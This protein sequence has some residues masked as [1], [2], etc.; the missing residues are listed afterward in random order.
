MDIKHNFK[1]LL[2]WDVHGWGTQKQYHAQ[3]C[4]V[5]DTSI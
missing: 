3:D 1:I 4:Q 5:L 2:F